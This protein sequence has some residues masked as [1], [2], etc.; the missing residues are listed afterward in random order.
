MAD[1]SPHDRDRR[2]RQDLL[3]AR[4]D[5]GASQTDWSMILDAVDA[6]A[7]SGA[8]ALDKVARRY[9]P[10]IF[11]YLRST[12]MD[13]HEAA[14]ITQSFVCDVILE[15]GLLAVATPER[16]RFRGLLLT[17]LKN[18]V[19]DRRRRATRRKRLPD[20]KPPLQLEPGDLEG[21]VVDPN[22]DP[23]AAFSAQW[24]AT[25]VRQVLEDVRNACI[26]AG[27]EAHWTVFEER[28]ARPMLLGEAPTE[29]SDLVE[30]LGLKDASQA[31][32]MVITVKRRVVQAL[33]AEVRSTVDEP[34]Q[35]EPEMIDLLRQLEAPK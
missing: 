13:V 33:V 21:A 3:S 7:P 31:A 5:P 30:R 12:G 24:A 8:A 20:G 10:A 1:G 25:L 35:V 29:Y 17:S 22:R 28:V 27:L 2:P 9:W 14:D 34:G 23:E 16:G 18:Y 11:A 32:N 4:S 15:R 6:S 19:R 26:H